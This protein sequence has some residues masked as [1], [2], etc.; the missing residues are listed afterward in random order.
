MGCADGGSAGDQMPPSAVGGGTA[1]SLRV[2]AL[3]AAE[4][5]QSC[6]CWASPGLS[7]PRCWKRGWE[8]TRS[9]GRRS[10]LRPSS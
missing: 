1:A 6:A 8:T 10:A 2:K 3:L 4:R 9:A 5:W 7:S